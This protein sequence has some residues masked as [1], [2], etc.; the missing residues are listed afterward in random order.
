[1]CGCARGGCHFVG[2]GFRESSEAGWSGFEGL[3][4]LQPCHSGDCLNPVNPAKSLMRTQFVIVRSEVRRRRM[5][6]SMGERCL[7]RRRDCRD[8]R[9]SLSE[10]ATLRSPRLPRCARNDRL[11]KVGTHE[12]GALTR[13]HFVIAR[14]EVRLWR[15]AISF[16]ERRPLP[17]RDCRAALAMTGC[18]KWVRMRLARRCRVGQIPLS[19]SD[20]FGRSSEGFETL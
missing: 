3:S 4:G 13:T 7:L 19:L 17:R 1:M 14:S 15:M 2:A 12:A 9:A 8:C 16:R 11:R 5:A 10:I 6:I 20:V 18:A